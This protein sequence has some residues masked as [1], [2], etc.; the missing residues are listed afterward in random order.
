MTGRVKQKLR[1][2]MKSLA[3]VSLHQRVLKEWAEKLA[4]PLRGWE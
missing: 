3:L 4:A 1:A 2:P